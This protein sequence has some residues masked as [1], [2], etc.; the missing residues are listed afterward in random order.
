[1][2]LTPLTAI[3]PVDGRYR[4]ATEPLADYFNKAFRES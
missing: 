4:R 1:M 3:S 2:T